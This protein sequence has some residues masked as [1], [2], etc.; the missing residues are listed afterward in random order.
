MLLTAVMVRKFRS[1]DWKTI[2]AVKVPHLGDPP[3]KIQ[4]TGAHD[5][6]PPLFFW[7][8]PKREGRARRA[9]LRGSI[10]GVE[11][12]RRSAHARR[13]SR[14]SAA[15]R[16]ATTSVEPVPGGELRAPRD[17]IQGLRR[18]TLGS[19]RGQST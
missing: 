19:R 18:G 11:V 7:G 8:D 17:A 5:S 10:P 2:R 6:R 9:L 12:N 1:G 3:P 13:C 4:P 15:R 16:L 14:G